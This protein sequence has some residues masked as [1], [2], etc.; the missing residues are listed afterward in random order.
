MG[1]EVRGSGEVQ[2]HEE[3]LDPKADYNVPD[4]VEDRSRVAVRWRRRKEA[5]VMA[6]AIERI[7][8]C[9]DVQKE[10]VARASVNSR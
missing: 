7:W 4:L 2:E 5:A 10:V 6:M 1:K 8:I 9:F 3:S